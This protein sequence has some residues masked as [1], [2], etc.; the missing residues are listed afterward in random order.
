M[1]IGPP[2]SVEIPVV[3]LEYDP[4]VFAKWRAAQKPWQKSGRKDVSV[5]G[6]Y[7]AL[8]KGGRLRFPNN[9]QASYG[10]P[11]F[12]TALALRRKGFTVWRGVQLFDYGRLFGGEYFGNNT[13]EVTE[14]W[15]NT[16]SDPF[17]S[18]IQ[19]TLRFPR[20][21]HPRNPD[22]VAYNKSRNEWRFC[23]IKS[24]RDRISPAQ[25][26]GLA[27]LHL[28]TGFPIAVVRLVPRGSHI[29]ARLSLTADIAYKKGADLSWI[30]S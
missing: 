5:W 21:R 13:A 29:K 18:E 22:L 17:P 23:E 14:R 26:S 16:I 8:V 20:A 11:E 2:R 12:H 4:Q 7:A 3:A 24:W 27:V 30:R 15:K 25:L 19:K 6:P 9:G 1:T 28:L 10:F